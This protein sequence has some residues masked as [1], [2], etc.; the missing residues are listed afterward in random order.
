MSKKKNRA[1]APAPVVDAEAALDAEI[2]QWLGEAPSLPGLR[3][4]GPRMRATAKLQQITGLDDFDA[5][6]GSLEGLAAFTADIDE[7]L[8]ELGGQAYIDWI[9][10][11]PFDGGLQ[12]A[13]ITDFLRTQVFPFLG[14]EPA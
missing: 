3:R 7:L 14:K 1:S 9:V 2:K 4:P 13:V 5:D 12:I 10:R 8:E 6:T 11:V